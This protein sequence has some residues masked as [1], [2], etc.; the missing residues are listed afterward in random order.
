MQVRHLQLLSQDTGVAMRE[1]IAMPNRLNVV[2][3]PLPRPRRRSAAP[4]RS[5]VQAAPAAPSTAAVPRQIPSHAVELRTSGQSGGGRAYGAPLCGC[6]TP[7]GATYMQDIVSGCTTG[8]NKRHAAAFQRGNMRCTA[9]G[10]VVHWLETVHTALTAASTACAYC[11]GSTDPCSG[12]LNWWHQ[13]CSLLS[14]ANGVTL[15]FA[16]HH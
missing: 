10:H 9:T 2:Y 8:A 6:P 16:L 7:L 4:C 5:A 13:Y 1:C 3:G 14:C 15:Q 11:Q 12:C